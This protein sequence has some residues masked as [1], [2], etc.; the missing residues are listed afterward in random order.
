MALLR[1]RAEKG[2]LSVAVSAPSDDVVFFRG[3]FKK[4]QQS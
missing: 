2:S 4:I 3:F 1:C